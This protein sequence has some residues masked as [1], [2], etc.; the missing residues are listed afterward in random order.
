MPQHMLAT[1]PSDYRFLK[2]HLETPNVY[3]PTHSTPVSGKQSS[4]VAKPVSNGGKKKKA[5]KSK[6]S[7][8]KPK[9]KKR[10]KVYASYQKESLDDILN[11]S[12]HPLTPPRQLF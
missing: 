10:H 3:D 1:L 11:N 8:A 7:L 9:A 2:H 6:I 12:S 4:N 5:T